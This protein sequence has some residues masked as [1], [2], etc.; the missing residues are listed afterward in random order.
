MLLAFNPKPGLAGSQPCSRKGKVSGLFQT[1]FAEPDQQGLIRRKAMHTLHV[2]TVSLTTDM[3]LCQVR[4]AM[5]DGEEVVRA[6]G[7]KETG[8]EGKRQHQGLSFK[9]KFLQVRTQES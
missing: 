8:E 3:L 9:V 2:I 5:E 6:E 1:A 4:P 7:E